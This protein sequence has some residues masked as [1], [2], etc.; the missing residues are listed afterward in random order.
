MI[1]I[2]NNNLAK[3]TYNHFNI[4]TAN[5]KLILKWSF[6]L[7]FITTMTLQVQA[8]DDE[9][10]NGNKLFDIQA[11]DEAIAAYQLALGKAPQNVTAFTQI[12]E[13]YRR[14]NRMQKAAEYYGKAIKTGN[15]QPEVLFRYGLVL[16]GLNRHKEAKQWF[17]SY[18][19]VAPQ[20][21]NHFADGCD[22]AMLQDKNKPSFKTYKELIN[23]SGAEFGATFYGNKVVYASSGV[24]IKNSAVVTKDNGNNN[25][26]GESISHLLVASASRKGALSKPALLLEGIQAKTDIGPVFFTS[27][28]NEVYYTENNFAHGVRWL[29]E[30]GLTLN[31]FN[32]KVSS[33]GDWSNAEPISLNGGGYSIAFPTL[34]DNGNTMYFASNSPDGYGGFDIYVSRKQG[35]KWSKPQ[36]LGPTVNTAGDEI[37][38]FS[39]GDLL[40]FSSNWHWGMGGYDIFSVKRSGNKWKDLTHLGKDVNSTRDDFGFIFDTRKGI[41]Y[42]SSNRLGGKG[43]LDIYRVKP[44][45][46][47]PVPIASVKQPTND[48]GN[49]NNPPGGNRPKP[50]NPNPPGGGKNQ[51]ISLK[52][53]KDGNLDPINN[54]T[55]NFSNCGEGTY[56]TNFNGIYQFNALAGLNCNVTISKDGF[57]SKTVNI[58]TNNSD[59][60]TIEVSLETKEVGYA[61][62]VADITSGSPIANAYITARDMVTNQELQAI[63]NGLGRYV[64]DMRQNRE[65]QIVISKKGY[66]E[67]KFK[68]NTLNG[69]NND[70]LGKVSLNRSAT[71]VPDGGAVV[72]DD[73][74]KIDWV[75]RGVSEAW[76]VQ[77]GVFRTANENALK[78]EALREFGNVFREPVGDLTR[79]KVGS[80]PNRKAAEGVKNA[81]IAK[82]G[83]YKDAILTRSTDKETIND[84][85]IDKTIDRSSVNI[86]DGGGVAPAPPGV[87]YKVQLGVY[88]KPQF[89]DKAKYAD[90]GII[91][92]TK[93]TL[94][95]GVSVTTFLLG[96]YT[97]KA[98]ADKAKA[99]VVARGN[100]QAFVVS[101]RNGKRVK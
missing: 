28:R 14:S 5:M 36:N 81:I 61:G 16:K 82:T 78:L 33:S 17:K 84:T 47:A 30:N 2:I 53:V 11:F 12:G 60:R 87:V 69:S 4:K 29:E 49:V 41:G 68:I 27:N 94:S 46:D 42:F 1:S 96:S 95:S 20:K 48:G 52:V 21:G 76:A 43:D 86:P 7:A 51:V 58:T 23:T 100:K 64:L 101:Y 85:Y 88:S 55:V 62:Y 8:Q 26:A 65:Y 70:I 9:I 75:S 37:T 35:G 89:F 31:I 34:A 91:S 54:A 19:A 74:K 66:Q 77:I 25:W 22:F 56:Y 92:T 67:N 97:N 45:G 50:N 79:Y 59:F 57:V 24:D 13:A 90:V 44:T 39:V 32:A 3:L 38:P 72:V 40:Y 98:D 63:T 83:M 71:W 93:K 15:A 6:V 99:A 80:F 10:E 18:A 73:G